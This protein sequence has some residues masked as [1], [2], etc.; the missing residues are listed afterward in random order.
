MMSSRRRAAGRGPVVEMAK[1]VEFILF[2]EP[3]V[4]EAPPMTV[5]KKRLP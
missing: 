4:L 2:R 1:V 5:W 3:W